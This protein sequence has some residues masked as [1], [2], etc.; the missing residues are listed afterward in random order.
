ME[1]ETLKDRFGANFLR[2]REIIS[3]RDESSSE[4][5]SFSLMDRRK[6]EKKKFWA[7]KETIKKKIIVGIELGIFRTLFRRW[8]RERC[9]TVSKAATRFKDCFVRMQIDRASHGS[10]WILPHPV[11]TSTQKILIN[12]H[13]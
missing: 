6:K 8:R 1:Q 13:P 9:S 11:S 10:R 5:R 4:R 2:R 7:D 12:F 3:F